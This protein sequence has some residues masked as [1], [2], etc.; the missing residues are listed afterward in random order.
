MFLEYFARTGQKEDSDC[1]FEKRLLL[2]STNEGK[3]GQRTLHHEAIAQKRGY[4]RSRVRSSSIGVG[5][6]VTMIGHV[7]A[8]MGHRKLV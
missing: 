4:V 2:M 3:V 5:D 6:H 1:V 7:R 8:G